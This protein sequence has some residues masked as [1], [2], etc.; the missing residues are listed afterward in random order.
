MTHA[1][2]PNPFLLLTPREIQVA[3]RLARGVTSRAI[4]DELKVS[5]K[6]VDTHR[7]HIMRKLGVS[8]NVQLARLAIAWRLVTIE[9]CSTCD[10]SAA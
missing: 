1:H 4:A 8:N 10:A 5:I 7:L 6:T 9:F 2:E 3:D